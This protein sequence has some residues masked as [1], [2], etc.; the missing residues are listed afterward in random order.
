MN[1]ETLA[2]NLLELAEGIETCIERR[3]QRPALILLYSA[4]DIASWLTGD[5]SDAKVGDRC[6]AW[7]DS[8]MLKAKP[9]NCTAI[10]LYAARCGVVHTMT[11][12]ARLIDQGRARRVL[13]G[14]GNAKTADLQ[15]TIRRMGQESEFAAVH[16]EELRDA[17]RLGLARLQGEMDADPALVCRVYE[18]AAQFFGDLSTG[19][20]GQFLA[21]PESAP[22]RGADP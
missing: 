3:L 4:I 2:K 19:L 10:D 13:Y 18:R 5:N 21:L 12:E 14:W 15:E 6:T 16:V 17:W 22:G 20:V 9:L 8:Y 1:A 11:S 7:V